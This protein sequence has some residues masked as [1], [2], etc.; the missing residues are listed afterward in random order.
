MA[1]SKSL[2][3]SVVAITMLLG[4]TAW[5]S[6]ASAQASPRCADALN[7]HNWWSPSRGDNFATSDPRWTDLFFATRMPDYTL[8]RTEG[9]VFRNNAPGTIPLYSWWSPSRG[10]NFITSDP[11]WAGRRGDTRA[12]DYDFVRIEGHIHDPNLAQPP[13][14]IMLQSFWSPSRADNFATID[15]RWIG[16]EGD[17]RSPDYTLYRTEGYVHLSCSGDGLF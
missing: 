3:G 1:S 14:T 17:K 16:R 15:S 2:L 7:L 8:F 13:N 12:P 5:S 10:D 11:A 4:A 9:W 6:S